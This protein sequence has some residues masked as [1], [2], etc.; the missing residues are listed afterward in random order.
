MRI[1][2]TV[3][4][5]VNRYNTRNPYDIA[6]QIGILVQK[7]HLGKIRGYYLLYAGIKCI[8]INSSIDDIHTEYTIM[9][10][11]LGH[12]VMHEEERCMFFEN[13]F[14]DKNKYEVQA[15]R[16]AAELLIPDSIIY[17]NPGMTRT[18]LSRLTGYDERLISFKKI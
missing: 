14:Y 2:K 3:K 1:K 16:F 13:T 6:D 8:C 11:E 18:Q 9:A 17:D 7:S 5:L 12:A 4:E 15:N 10:H